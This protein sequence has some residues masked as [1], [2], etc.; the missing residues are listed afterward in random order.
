SSVADGASRRGG[1]H[2]GHM[3]TSDESPAPDATPEVTA[4]EPAPAV[5]TPPPPSHPV[6]SVVVGAA[7]TAFD[8]LA[9]R[10]DRVGL[11]AV[12]GGAMFEHGRS[13]EDTSELQSRVVLVCRFLFGN[14][15]T[16]YV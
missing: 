12:V 7:A 6:T 10:R 16:A 11:P 2:C 3:T 14:I 5:E 8:R 13:E 4:E 9:P 1:G 15:Y